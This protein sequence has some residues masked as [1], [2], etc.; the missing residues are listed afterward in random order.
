LSDL[1]AQIPVNPHGEIRKLK[2]VKGGSIK[3]T[4][5]DVIRAGEGERKRRDGV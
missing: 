5:S 1:L 2:Y 4:L 3:V